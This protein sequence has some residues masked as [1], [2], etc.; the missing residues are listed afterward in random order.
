MLGDNVIVF[1]D[2][3]DMQEIARIVNDLESS[4]RREQFSENRYAIYFAPG[5]YTRAGLLNVG[6][7]TS[8]AGLGATPYEVMTS[9]RNVVQLFLLRNSSTPSMLRQVIFW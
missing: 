7:Y 9:A 2:T 4:M 1:H 3:D 5:D 8:M 6:Y